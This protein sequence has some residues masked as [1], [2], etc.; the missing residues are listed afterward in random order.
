MGIEH[1][2]SC[3][4]VGDVYTEEEAPFGKVHSGESNHASG[5]N[6]ENYEKY[7]IVPKTSIL[8]AGTGE[9]KISSVTCIVLYL[10]KT[11]ILIIRKV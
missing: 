9:W 7:Y 2:F 8:L 4:N 5:I 6:K 10:L 11:I 1:G 3:I